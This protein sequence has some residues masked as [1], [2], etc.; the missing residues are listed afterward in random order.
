MPKHIFSTQYWRAI[1]LLV[2]ISIK[3][4][5][6]NTILG[7]IWGLI[8]PFINVTVIS[9]FMSFVLRY[10]PKVIVVNLVGALT[11]WTFILQ[12]MT[13]TSNSLIS[14]S[15]ILK[16]TILPKTYF[17]I[18][19]ILS[20]VHTLFYS[21]TAMY[22]ALILIFPEFL[23]WKI[24]F[25]PLLSL[26]LIISVMS[27]GVLSAF[28]TPY[29]RDIP[30]FVSVI[31]GVLYWTIPIIY[32]YSIVPESKRIFFEW[33]PFFIVIR[34]M[35]DLVATG[36]IPGLM[37]IVKSWIVAAIVTFISFIIYRRIS[38]EVIYYL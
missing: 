21:F 20:N 33:N 29:V 15:E 11:F 10:D 8:Q 23:S 16:R 35:Q 24:I 4:R 13:S 5:D 9:Y 30:Q 19:D 34:P 25:I 26:P 18:A 32:P 36:D 7:G 27:A 37:M 14:N 6:A 2:S 31:L 1:L 12:S 3:K 28:L 38:R 17:P 22:V